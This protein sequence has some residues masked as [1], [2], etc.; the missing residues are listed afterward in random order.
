[1]L[2]GVITIIIL[3]LLGGGS[4]IPSGGEQFIHYIFIT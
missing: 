2:H 3:L 4:G 1:M